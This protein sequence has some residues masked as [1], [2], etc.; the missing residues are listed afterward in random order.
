MS[1]SH[2]FEDGKLTKWAIYGINRLIIV[3]E[4]VENPIREIVVFGFFFF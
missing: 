4:F 2:L 3:T 1:Y